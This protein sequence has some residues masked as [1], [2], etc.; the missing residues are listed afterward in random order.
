M[1]TPVSLQRLL[2]LQ[3]RQGYVEDKDLRQLHRE[4]GQ[5]LSQLE[6][7]FSSYPLFRREKPSTAVVRVCRDMTCRL[8]DPGL[9]DRLAKSASKPALAIEEVSCMGQCDRAPVLL[10]RARLTAASGHGEAR[11]EDIL[12]PA[13]VPQIL[14]LARRAP[15]SQSLTPSPAATRTPWSIDPYGG[16]PDYAAVR[17]YD[18]APNPE[19]LIKE[20]E[21][22]NLLGMGGAGFPAHRK[23]RDVRDQPV[24]PK[25]VVCNGDE[26]EPG[27]FK[28]RELLRLT[29]WLI[30]E[31]VLLGARVIGA[32]TAYIYIRH[33]YPDQIRA[34][35]QAIEHATWLGLCG[36]GTKG[37]PRELDICV[38]VSPGGYICGEQSALIEAIEGKRAEPRNRPPEIT[39]NGL[40]DKPT[41]LN[42]VETL[43]WVPAIARRGGAWYAGLGKPGYKGR[44][45][46]SISGDVA[47]PGVYEIPIGITLGEFLEQ[48]ANRSPIAD[49]LKA[50]APS[51]PSGGFLPRYLPLSELARNKAPQVVLDRFARKGET[52]LDVLRLEMDLNAWRSLGL[53]LGAGLAVYGPGTDMVPHA[54]WATEFYRN[55]SCGKCVPCR[56]GSQKLTE[57]ADDLVQRRVD[58]P[59]LARELP[60]I[61]DLAHT[62]RQTTICGLGY[63]APEP[64]ISLLRYFD[65]DVRKY[66]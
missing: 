7:L 13:T 57:L 55:E 29:P 54:L 24:T 18:E 33:E 20:L 63:V 15:S 3:E 25:Y 32:S 23:W 46:F 37:T 60:V 61:Q 56:L 19:K 9:R 1:E 58:P 35:R 45:F 10:N 27:T 11:A 34:V 50:I 44:R 4:T 47:H 64:L 31:G 41:L 6:E 5:P 48:Y 16:Q 12:A 36:P 52:H 59:R 66:L 38:F 49:P 26:S 14:D 43:A 2:E 65:E 17:A 42:N 22:A 28:D 62:M 53:M 51:G 21:T 8:R 39:A 30:V 40:F